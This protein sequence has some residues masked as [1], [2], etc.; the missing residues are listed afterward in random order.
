MKRTVLSLVTVVACH[1]SSVEAPAED[2]RGVRIAIVQSGY[3]GSPDAAKGFLGT[4]TS[5]LERKT[6]M[7]GL[8]AIYHNVPQNALADIARTPP[9]FGVVS[10]GFYLENRARLGLVARLETTPLERYLIMVRRGTAKSL[11]DLDGQKVAGGALHEPGFVGSVVFPRATIEDWKPEPTLRPSRALR[12]LTRGNYVALILNGREHRSFG[13]LGKLEGLTKLAESEALPVALV[14][15]F[16]PDVRKEHEKGGKPKPAKD[17][18][19]IDRRGD[20]FRGLHDDTSGGEI[21][22]TM[23]CKGF[24]EVDARRLASIEKRFDAR[25]VKTPPK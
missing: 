4:L 2:A 21:V 22:A 16:A 7:D 13:A 3:P 24:V 10:L 25:T 9:R 17:S 18:G 12:K 14:V 11:A 19:E 5:Y 6:T 8:S 20:A 15:S 1:W 23:G